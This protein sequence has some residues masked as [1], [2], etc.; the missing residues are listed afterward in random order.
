ML[1]VADS[2]KLLFNGITWCAID[3]IHYEVE[4]KRR[5]GERNNNC[6]NN[7]Q[8]I[9]GVPNTGMSF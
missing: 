2:I 9:N 4:D 3:L 8:N 7:I 6:R 5:R 1:S